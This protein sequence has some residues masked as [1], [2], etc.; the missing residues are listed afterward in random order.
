MHKPII[1]YILLIVSATLAENWPG[2][3]GPGRQGISG[4]TKLPISW[5]A[6]ENIA[7]KAT[8]DGKG[9]S[10]PIVW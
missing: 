8:I 5:S 10:S 4:E 3:R 1:V 6:T 2:F 9:W 7:W